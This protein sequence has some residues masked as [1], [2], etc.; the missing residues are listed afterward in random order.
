VDERLNDCNDAVP[1]T[2][3]DDVFLLL[4]SPVIG[5]VVC[6]ELRMML[7]ICCMQVYPI[8]GYNINRFLIRHQR[9][10]TLWCSI[11]ELTIVTAKR[12][13]NQS[14]RKVVE[15]L[16]VGFGKMVSPDRGCPISQAKVTH[17]P[18]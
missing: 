17:S 10:R 9:S 12:I 7:T 4:A 8:G 1:C 5:T 16:I 2:G 6:R 3:N 13:S 11:L 14:I 15:R 18:R